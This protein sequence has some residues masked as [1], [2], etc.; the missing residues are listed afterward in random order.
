MSAA[1]ET[2][3][4]EVPLLL[5]EAMAEHGAGRLDAAEALYQRCLAA[6][7]DDANALHLRGVLL[8]QRG[9]HAEAA[10]SIDRAL[11]ARP[12][13][14][15]FHNNL[16][17]VRIELGDAAAAEA[18]Y[19]RA[20]ALDGGRLDAANN[21][22]VLLSRRGSA[23]EAEALLLKVLELAP[24]FADARQN[25]AN[26][27]LRAGRLPEAVQQCFDGLITAPR[28]T[29]LRRLLGA[30][31][32]LM[33]RREQAIEVY[34]HWLEDDPG[35]P[36]AEF[37]LKACTGE[38][39]PP[40]APDAYVARVFDGF[41]ASFDAKLASLE[42]KAPEFVLA[43]VALRCGK[44]Q[45]ALDVLDAGCGTGL[46]GPQLAPWARRLA[47]VDLSE[48]MLRQAVGRRVYDELVAGEL[49]EFLGLR[50]AAWDLIVSADTLCYFGAL[51]G[52]AAAARAALR[53]GGTLAFTV[54]AH[55]DVDGAPAYRLHEHGRYSHRGGYVRAVLGSAG[56]AA[57]ELEPAVL[58]MEAGE[59]VN[60]WLVAAR[61]G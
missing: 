46:C 25:L 21:L 17:N 27:Y 22:G 52:F 13:E 32:S 24:D 15:M 53:E 54:E 18:C 39:V 44:P 60:G 47:G 55:A 26:H 2:A 50:A 14:A 35:N 43:A 9:R 37:H 5:R 4:A 40:R 7:P 23:D 16:G 29:A 59:P 38:D 8:A 20:L 61:A 48:G 19:R 45:R 36:L 6:D 57:I 51:E 41:A 28:S 10:A 30:A 42:Y 12:A 11:A 31:Y 58:R 34:R 33:G 56:F 3:D 1:T 49:V